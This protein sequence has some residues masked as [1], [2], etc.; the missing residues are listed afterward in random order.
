MLTSFSACC[1]VCRDAAHEATSVACVTRMRDSDIRLGYLGWLEP[2]E[3][4]PSSP[5]RPLVSSV[6]FITHDEP[7]PSSP[8]VGREDAVSLLA[9][10]TRIRAA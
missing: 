8:A 4:G 3:A 5:A 6:S 7:G 9:C 1:L 2:D 10:L